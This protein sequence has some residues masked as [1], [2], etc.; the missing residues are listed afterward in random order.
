RLRSPTPGLDQGI[1]GG[2]VLRHGAGR[3]LERGVYQDTAPLGRVGVAL[4]VPDVSDYGPNLL[5]RKLRRLGRRTRQTVHVMP[6]P[7]EP[8]RHRVAHVSGGARYKHAHNT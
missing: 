2:L 1:D 6:R 4:R 8:R 3:G 5:T 7:S